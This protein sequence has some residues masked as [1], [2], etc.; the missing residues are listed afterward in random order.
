MRLL[1]VSKIY[2]C[3]SNNKLYENNHLA[4]HYLKIDDKGIM[5][6]QAKPITDAKH[7][8]HYKPGSCKK[9][10]YLQQNP[11][12]DNAQKQRLAK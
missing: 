8:S 7:I 5:I 3:S 1:Y 12:E 2:N 11:N 6:G 9:P 4:I 10:S